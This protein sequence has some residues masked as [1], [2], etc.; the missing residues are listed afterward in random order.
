MKNV[1]LRK[2][3]FIVWVAIFLSVFGALSACKVGPNYKRPDISIPQHYKETSAE[4][5]IAEPKDNLSR[6]EW[7][8]IFADAKLNS[9]ETDLNANN[10]NIAIAAANYDAAQALVSAA[11]AGYFPNINTSV[12]LTRKKN[13]EQSSSSA[14]T[15]TSSSLALDAAW[16]VDLWGSVRRLVESSKASAEASAAQLAA[17]RLS[18]QAALAQYYFELRTQDRDQVLLDDTVANYRQAVVV[19][20]NNYAAGVAARVDILAMQNQL[21]NAVAKAMDNKINRAQY[22]HAIAVLIGQAPANFTLNADFFATKPPQIPVQLPSSLLEHRP[23]IAEAERNAAAANAKIGVAVAAYFP[24]FSLGATVGGQNNNLGKWLSLPEFVWSLGPQLAATIFD[25][26]LRRAN[27]KA[28]FANYQAS[29][30]NY[31]QTVL[32]A[33][34]EV[35]DNLSTI[36]ELSDEVTVFDQVTSDAKKTLKIVENEYRAGTVSRVDI[37]NAENAVFAAEKNSADINGLRLTAT[38]GLIKALGAKW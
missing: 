10:Q 21:N 36:S 31:R 3:Y 33:L 26:G 12:A 29:A 19:T 18:E 37:I 2:I 25:G 5:K 28:A 23:D 17:T 32:S 15:R 27:T 6:G 14:M 9:L 8:Q 13:A 22:E 20:K 4:W 11:R 7:W 24:T 1:M 34:Q 30:A 35:E 38:V 16:E